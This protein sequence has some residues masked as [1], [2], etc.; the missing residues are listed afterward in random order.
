MAQAFVVRDQLVQAE[1]VSVI[2]A[3]SDS[4]EVP[5]DFHGNKYVLLTVADNLIVKDPD[6]P[7]QYLAPNWREDYKTVIN[8]EASRRINQAFPL[9]KQMNYSAQFNNYGE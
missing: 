1:R 2:A 8:A 9:F 5:F 3:Y 7:I 4:S 6:L